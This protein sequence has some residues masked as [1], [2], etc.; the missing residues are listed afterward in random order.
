MNLNTPL[1]FGGTVYN[2]NVYVSPKGTVTFGQG[3]YTFWDYP[4]TP[5][6]SIAAYD[7]HA[8][9]NG[10]SWGAENNLY[11]RYGS[12]K[13]SICVDWKVM[14]WGQSSG[15]PIYIRMIAEVNPENYTWTP[16][17]QVSSNVSPNARY[18]VRYTFNGEV[19]PLTIQ[20]ITTPPVN[21]PQKPEGASV[22]EEGSSFEFT[23]PQGKKVASVSGYYGSPS[24]GTKGLDVSSAL[25][26]LFSGET[27]GTVQVSNDTFGSD[28]APGTSKV[29]IVLITYEDVPVDTTPVN[30]EPTQPPAEP[31]EP[32]LPPTN[33][34]NPTPGPSQ[35]PSPEPTTPPQQ[36]ETEPPAGPT[37][38]PVE[39][40]PEP[41]PNSPIIP[42]DPIIPE[43]EREPQVEP[44]PEP[45][46]VPPT[47][48]STPKPTPS[49]EPTEEPTENE[50]ESLP[51]PEQTEEPG[52]IEPIATAEELPEEL[53][54]ED[55]MQVDLEQIVATDLSEA[56]VEALIEAALETFE[57]AE[58]G[59]PE[60][61]Q[62]LDAL[63]LAAQADDIVLD[64]ALAAIPLLGDVLGGATELINF[65]GNAG[66]DMSPQ[67]RE[68][69]EKIVVTA[70]V[71]VQAALA[72]ISISGI[73]TTVNLRNGA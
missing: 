59:S 46:P 2:G 52:P 49:E 42:V 19:F 60:Y 34:V 67:V 4:A 51:E 43:P 12:T 48:E 41:S 47:E 38:P 3:D 57:T 22:I 13:T 32:T 15:E 72:A 58:Q 31:V 71:A 20:T 56:Q 24:D 29:L 39:P 35:E 6:I 1:E 11:V 61:E 36:G 54:S 21:P 37:T 73:A 50:P 65:L 66:A 68:D 70:I 14:Q 8:F 16:T 33:P 23:A 55:L 26:E 9:A 30:P 28:P 69:S 53:S 63:F 45:T 18:G 44:S 27:S 17:F 40:S 10:V 62:A 5:S 64:E 25:S 7:Y